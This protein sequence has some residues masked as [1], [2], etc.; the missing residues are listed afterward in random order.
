MHSHPIQ[1]KSKSIVKRPK[2]LAIEEGKL[3]KLAARR[4]PSKPVIQDQDMIP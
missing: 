2:P 1:R 3:G 4:L